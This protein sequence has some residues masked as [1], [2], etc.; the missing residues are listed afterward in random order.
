MGSFGC[1]GEVDFLDYTFS[2]VHKFRV[3]PLFNKK[4]HV[5][6]KKKEHAADN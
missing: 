2:N 1:L 3:E 6:K 4:S 5:V